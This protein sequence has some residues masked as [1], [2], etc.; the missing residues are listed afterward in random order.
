[1]A[2]AGHEVDV[3]AAADVEDVGPYEAFVVGSATYI[4]HWRK[5]ATTF[6]GR[7]DQRI[8]ER[9]CPHVTTTCSSAPWTPGSW[10]LRSGR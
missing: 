5:E 1:M 10:A 8:A 4:G 3:L 9:R 6:A 2:S 7:L